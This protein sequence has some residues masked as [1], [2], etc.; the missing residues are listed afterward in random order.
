MNVLAEVADKTASSIFGCQPYC[1]TC[2]RSEYQLRVHQGTALEACDNCHVAFKCKNCQAW[3]HS[4]QTCKFYQLFS[5]EELFSIDLFNETG[6][7]ISKSPVP[8]PST[9]FTE[10]ASLSG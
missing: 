10:L 2:Y 4:D 1:N 6:D 8:V 7:V 3:N 5:S 9:T